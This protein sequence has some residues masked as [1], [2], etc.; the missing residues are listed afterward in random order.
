MK[1][2]NKPELKCYHQINKTNKNKN[3]EKKFNGEQS[4][5]VFL[6]L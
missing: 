1:Y 2:A 3:N 4:K 5:I 6:S